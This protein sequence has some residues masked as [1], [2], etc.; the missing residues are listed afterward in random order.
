M[1]AP[2]SPLLD[3]FSAIVGAPY[4]LREPGAMAPY[5]TEPREKFRGRTPLVLRPGTV[6]EVAAILTLA[7]APRTGIVPQGGHTGL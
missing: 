4:A 5:L 1:N 7:N 3:Q 2:A 6:A